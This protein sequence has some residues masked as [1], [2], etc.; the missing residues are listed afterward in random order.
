MRVLQLIDSLN[1]GGAERMA[2]NIANAL[3][4]VGIE[5]FICTTRAEGA[6]KKDLKS[7][8][9]YCFLNK[10]TA[11]DFS[12]LL[13]LRAFVG[14]HNIDIV[15]AHS[16]SY[17]FATLLKISLPKIKIV[18]HDHYGNSEIL[19]KRKYLFLKISSLYF[20]VI[21]SVNKR[22]KSWAEKKLFCPNVFYI[23]NFVSQEE[24]QHSVSLKNQNSLKIICIANLRPQKDHLNLL[25]AFKIIEQKNLNASLHLVGAI[26]DTD[27]LKILEDFIF[28]NR[29]TQVYI[30][31]AQTAIQNIPKTADLAVLSSLS[32]G[33]P[34][35]LLEYGVAG[36]PVV[37]TDVGECK[38]VVQNFGII[39]PPKN[40]EALA[41]GMLHYLNNK[42]IRMND[43]S[44]FSSHIRENYTENAVIPELI[45]IYKKIS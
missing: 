23:S 3:H 28:T 41:Q 19:Q 6:L 25:K 14:T 8:V 12:A 13:K 39:V 26:D 5:S 38:T 35:S 40:P 4:R 21:I 1:P 36:L 2:V 32:E 22:L 16:T 37:C 17:F 10:K 33:L 45:N 11:L 18:W 7:D 30:Y 43:A 34:L 42:E 31:G 27:N 24:T 44:S 15:H 20:G 9:N 29:L